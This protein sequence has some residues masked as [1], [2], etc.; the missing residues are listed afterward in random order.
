M[1]AAANLFLQAT[2]PTLPARQLAQTRADRDA[3][4]AKLPAAR[5][6]LARCRAALQQAQ[7]ALPRREELAARAEG[8]RS[9]LPRYA[10]LEQARAA[11]DKRAAALADKQ[12]RIEIRT[13]TLAGEQARLQTEQAER[14]GLRDS[15]V[16]LEKLRSQ[17]GELD[18]RRRELEDLNERLA[19]CRRAKKEHARAAEAYLQAQQAAEA[20]Q[21]AYMRLNRADPNRFDLLTV[22]EDRFAVVL[23]AGHPLSSR[24]Q[25]DPAELREEAFLQLNE[26]TRLFGVVRQLC[27]RAG[28]EPRVLFTGDHIDNI[29]DLVARGMGISILMEQAVRRQRT[30]GLAVVPLLSDWRSYLCFVRLHQA[31]RSRAAGLFWRYLH[32][33]YPQSE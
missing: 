3:C 14:D 26:K 2:Q 6:E 18:R 13:Q 1:R 9:Q 27:A 5:E 20:A 32:R 25:I 29:L 10:E 19:G 33:C 4:Q 17:A 30:P 23:P 22:M 21:T 31:E 12:A 28:F 7:A 8:I 15:L 24:P 11:R 16:E